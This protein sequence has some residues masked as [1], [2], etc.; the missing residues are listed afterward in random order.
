[1]AKASGKDSVATRRSAEAITIDYDELFRSVVDK[2]DFVPGSEWRTVNQL[3]ELWGKSRKRASEVAAE[4]VVAGRLEKRYSAND[5]HYKSY[6]R[7]T[8]Q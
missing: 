3:A 7:V 8:D 6:F 4:L 2:D 1:M 5:G